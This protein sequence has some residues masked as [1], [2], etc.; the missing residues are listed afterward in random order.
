MRI[1]LTLCVSICCCLVCQVVCAQM[2][3]QEAID[4]G[5]DALE[6][7]PSFPWYDGDGDSVQ[8]IDVEPPKDLKNR[9]SRWQFKPLNWSF[10]PWL[11][12]LLE[13]LVWIVIALLL[14]LLV[15]FMVRTFM[16]REGGFTGDAE[17][18]SIELTGDVDR[19]EALPF[20]IKRP[21]SD[22]LSEA[23]RHY[24]EGQ[25]GEAIIYLYSY[26]L[27]QLDKHHVI[28]LT[29]GKTNRQ[30]LREVRRR[31]SLVGVMEQTMIAFEDVFFGDHELDKAQFERCWNRLDEFQ[32]QL[33]AEHAV[34]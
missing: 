12:K 26:Q 13:V 5:A 24:E 30:Y 6:S 18:S 7:Y 21:Q 32:E 33:E 2:S 15:Y 31:S 1:L 28:R 17:S 27:V 3:D 19:V 11:M 14:T 16:A 25:Y 4:A 20:Q 8:R 29:K 10:P 9:H 23:R 22:L 34:A